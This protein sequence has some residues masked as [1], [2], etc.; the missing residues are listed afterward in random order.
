MGHVE[1]DSPQSGMR[2]QDGLKEYPVS[3][4]HIDNSAE[5]RKVIRGGKPVTIWKRAAGAGSS[6]VA[7]DIVPSFEL[8]Y[9]GMPWLGHGLVLICQGACKLNGI[10]TL[11]QS[12][13]QPILQCPHVSETSGESLAG[14]SGTPRIAAEG[15]DAFARLEK[16]G[17]I[18]DEF[19]KVC[20]EA[21]K[22]I[23]E[24]HCQGPRRQHRMEIRQQPPS[25]TLASTWRMTSGLPRA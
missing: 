7:I 9:C 10:G 18:R 19:V 22:K 13:D 3:A 4:A 20:E 5:L 23:T 21:T 14:P 6:C 2:L 24:A 12:Y 17:A 15:D 1:K 11:L 16:L 25:D 8:I